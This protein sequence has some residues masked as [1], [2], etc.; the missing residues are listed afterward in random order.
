MIEPAAGAAST[1]QGEAVWVGPAVEPAPVIWTARL[2]TGH[3]AIFQVSA[4]RASKAAAVI[5]LVA[6]VDSADSVV[7]ASAAVVDSV[8]I[9]WAV[10]EDSVVAALADSAAAD[11]GVDDE[12]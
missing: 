9:G 2:R 10:E 8:V 6:V 1:G 3:V 7:I 4:S 12:N 5:A 11:S